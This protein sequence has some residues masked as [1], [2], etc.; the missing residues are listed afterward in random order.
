MLLTLHRSKNFNSRVEIIGAKYF[1][2]YVGF[3]VTL[4]SGVEIVQY[5]WDSVG[6]P[7]PTFLA[8][9]QLFQCGNGQ[10]LMRP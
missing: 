9:R 4:L 3:V 8:Q 5:F 10:T 1:H 7:I 6:K 2:I